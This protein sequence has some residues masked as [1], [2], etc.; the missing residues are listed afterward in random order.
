MAYRT[1]TQTTGK[2]GKGDGGEVGV[3]FPL[4]VAVV[5]ITALHLVGFQSLA[6]GI[7]LAGIGLYLAGLLIAQLRAWAEAGVAFANETATLAI[8]VLLLA[9]W[10]GVIYLAVAGRI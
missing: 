6:A 1:L 2:P 4:V 7:F 8:I 9:G 10:I 5:S 3:D